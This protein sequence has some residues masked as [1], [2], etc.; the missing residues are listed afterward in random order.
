MYIRI[1]C[2]PLQLIREYPPSSPLA[3]PTHRNGFLPN[4]SKPVPKLPR[5]RTQTLS[6]ILAS[7]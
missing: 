7:D 1:T 2:K 5:K 4:Q 6:I 3:N